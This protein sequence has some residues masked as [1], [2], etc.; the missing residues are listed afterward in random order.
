MILLINIL[1]YKF[2]HLLIYSFGKYI[3]TNVKIIHVKNTANPFNLIWDIWGQR[4]WEKGRRKFS[5]NVGPENVQKVKFSTRYIL[6]PSFKSTESIGRA[7]DWC[8]APSETWHLAKPGPAARKVRSEIGTSGQGKEEINVFKYCFKKCN[9]YSEFIK[10]HLLEIGSP[11]LVISCPHP[12][13]PAQ[14]SLKSWRI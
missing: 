11:K 3:L 1:F 9:K 7:A 6:F 4:K 2:V 12:V 14:R 5:F 8:W 10:N 13:V